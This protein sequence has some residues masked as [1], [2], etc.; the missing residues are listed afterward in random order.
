MYMDKKYVAKVKL[1][2]NRGKLKVEPGAVIELGDADI[3]DGINIANLERNAGIELY[4][5]DERA[6]EI[7]QW[8]LGRAKEE[9]ES[10]KRENIRE[11]RRSKRN[12]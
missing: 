7:R 3:A 10:I 12:G 4:T 11:Q 2:L 1:M 9:R 8:W 6:E 5:T